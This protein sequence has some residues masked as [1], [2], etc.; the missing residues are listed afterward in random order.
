M[1]P[2]GGQLSAALS[3]RTAEQPSRTWRLDADTGRIA[4][5]IDGLEAVKQ[6][7]Y[8]ILL[9]ERYAY[10][11]YS[12]DYGVELWSLMGQSPAYAQSEL[13]RRIAEALLQDSRIGNVRDFQFQYA[14]DTMTVR[15][16][17]ETSAGT[18]DQEVNAVV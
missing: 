15:F 16:T 4:G 10:M 17:V 2:T 11:A 18:F 12:F 7:V 8:K 5:K 9:T 3:G 14:G 1:I 6:A 13:R